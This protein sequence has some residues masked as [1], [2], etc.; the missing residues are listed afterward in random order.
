MRSRH[1]RIRY[2]LLI[3][4]SVVAAGQPVFARILKT[5]PTPSESW[6]PLMPLTI[7]GGFEYETDSEQSQYDFPLLLEYNFTDKLKLTVEP[8]FVAIDSK[9]EG[10]NSVSGF[11][12]LETSVEYEFLPELRYRP[13]LTAEGVI[14]WPTAS[15]SDIGRPGEDYSIGLIMSKDLVFVNLDLNALY[16]FVGDSEQE[17]AF[18]LSLAAE[19][20]L[21]HYLDLE[22]EVVQ[23]FGG[24]ARGQPGTLSGLGNTDGGGNETEGTL[25]LAWH[26][27]KH[28]KLEAGGTLRTDG[29]WQFLSA[30]EYSF[31]GED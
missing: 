4:V 30:W 26:V 2:G 11:G 27:T 23:P 24:G 1:T 15:D 5:R 6:T 28:L 19:R 3:L 25:G 17:N 13:A 14:K 20:R 29:S 31:S 10:G 12:D 9:T 21:N 22:A 16:T 18:E 7:G 8:N